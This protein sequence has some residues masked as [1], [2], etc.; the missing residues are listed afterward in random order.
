MPEAEINT[1][2]YIFYDFYKKNI[3]KSL[4][5]IHPN[6]ITLFRGVLIW[7]L[8]NNLI[9]NE[10]I[11]TSCLLSCIIMI[12]DI[13]DGAQSRNCNKSTKLG[14]FLDKFVDSIWISVTI[15][16]CIIKIFKIKKHIHIQNI[17]IDRKYFIF[18]LLLLK[19]LLLLQIMDNLDNNNSNMKYLRSIT[20]NFVIF[21]FIT[22]LIIKL[23]LNNYTKTLKE[24]DAGK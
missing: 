8:V 1:T 11:L 13:F 14:A 9:N 2:D 21:T 16:Y 18:A 12:L 15:I 17:V 24:I 5:F 6:M 3:P 22:T 19:I 7:P 10:S 4:C 20:N 23:Y